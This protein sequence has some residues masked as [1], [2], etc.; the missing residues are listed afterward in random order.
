MKSSITVLRWYDMG[1]SMLRVLCKVRTDNQKES[2]LGMAL[3]GLHNPLH[4]KK[5][6][7]FESEEF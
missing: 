2:F 3:N 7:E 4:R 1:I 5:S 6:K